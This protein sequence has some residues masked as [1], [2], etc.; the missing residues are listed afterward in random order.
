MSTSVT[1]VSITP[2]ASI[3]LRPHR[4]SWLLVGLVIGALLLFGFWLRQPREDGIGQIEGYWT[5]NVQYGAWYLANNFR[6][7]P[8]LGEIPRVSNY[9]SGLNYGAVDPTNTFFTGA[10]LL[11]SGER[12]V[13]SIGRL[14]HMT[15]WQGLIAIPLAVLALYARFT[16]HVG[17]RISPL[18]VAILYALA[19]FPSYGMVDWALSGGLV[20]PLGWLLFFLIYLA[21]F[22]QRYD[23]RFRWQWACLSAV[24]IILAQPAYHTFALVLSIFVVLIWLMQRPLGQH[25]VSTAIVQLTLVAFLGYLMYYAITYLNDYVRLGMLSLQDLYKLFQ[26]TDDQ[27][28][29]YSLTI[30]DLS[31]WWHIANYAAVALPAIWTGLIVLRRRFQSDQDAQIGR[32]QWIWLLALLPLA[33]L[34]F[35]WKG[36][37][38]VYERLLQYGTLLALCSAA[39]L[40][41]TRPLAR[42]VLLGTAIVC[43]VVTSFSMQRIGVSTRSYLTNQEMAAMT[44]ITQNEGCDKVIFTDFRIGTTFGYWGCFNVVGPTASTLSARDR[45]DDLA[46]LFY[47]GDSQRLTAAIDQVRTTDGR[48]PEIIFLSRRFSH[49]HIGFVLP[50]TRLQPIPDTQWSTY[51]ALPGWHVLFENESTMVLGRTK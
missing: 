47:A 21:L 1:R 32:Y 29:K 36:L 34:F 28:L 18:A 38:G 41:A 50:D 33:G 10:A 49:P 30:L 13:E 35:A 15:P 2:T 24:G 9:T 43:V 45:I 3:A 48:K 4:W 19:A 42:R 7:F 8:L 23:H 26:G 14:Y 37:F 40:L 51:R 17:G 22:A 27:R 6:L 44:W 39:Y 16:R 20:V 5:P 25:Y 31:L 46:D 12:E 11:L